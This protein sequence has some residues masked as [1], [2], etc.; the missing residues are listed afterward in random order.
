MPSSRSTSASLAKKKIVNPYIYRSVIALCMEVDAIKNQSTVFCSDCNLFVKFIGF[1]SCFVFGA[2]V[3]ALYPLFSAPHSPFSLLRSI[4]AEAFMSTPTFLPWLV[5]Q[6]K[7]F[8]VV[9]VEFVYFSIGIK[10]LE[11]F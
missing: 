1:Q 4:F 7:Y 2:R 10:S 8:L 3:S 11:M 9:I 6:H 5:F